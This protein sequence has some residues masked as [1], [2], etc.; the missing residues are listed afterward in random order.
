MGGI[1]GTRK[2]NR[3]YKDLREG[4]RIVPHLFGSGGAGAYL[5]PIHSATCRK[6]SSRALSM[7]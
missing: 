2:G 4:S 5:I 1:N 7:K 6:Y 3:G